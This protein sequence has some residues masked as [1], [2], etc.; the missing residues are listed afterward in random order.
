MSPIGSHI[1]PYG[2]RERRTTVV[3]PPADKRL[4]RKM[5]A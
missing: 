3:V 1:D 5:C 2:L 4:I